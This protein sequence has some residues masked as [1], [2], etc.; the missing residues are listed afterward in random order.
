[1]PIADAPLAQIIQ[2]VEPLDI[3]VWPG[4][5]IIVLDRDRVIESRPDYDKTRAANRGGVRIRTVGEVLTEILKDRIPVNSYDTGG[6]TGRKQF[7]IRRWYQLS[8]NH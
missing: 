7:V 4:H 5:V 2:A 8:R 3:I 1:V 6:T